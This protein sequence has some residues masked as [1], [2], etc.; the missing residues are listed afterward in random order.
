MSGDLDPDEV[1]A[2]IDKYFGQWQPG[3]DVTQPQFPEQPVLTEP[4]DT[5]V[6]GLEAEQLWLGWR[7]DKA[8]SLQ[9]DTLEIVENMLSNGTAG[10]LDLDIN[11][12]MKMLEAWGG[13][14]TMMDYSLFILSGTPKDGQSLDEVRQLLLDEIAKLKKGEFSEDLLPSV[15]NNLRLRYYNA[16][17]VNRSRADMFV[18][19][20]IN[21]TPWDQQTQRI[22]RMAGMTKQQIV[23]F[24][25]RHFTDGYAAVYKRQGVD[26]NQKKI[27]K[28]AIT[29]ISANRNN[30][31]QFV[32]DIQAVEVK[33]IEP[34]FVDFDRDLTQGRIRD[35]AIPYAYVKNSENGRFQLSFRYTF[36]M[37]ADARYENAAEYLDYLGTDSLTATQLKQQFYKLACNYSIN[38]GDRVITVSLNGLSENMAE[39]VRLLEN[40]MANAK[41]D[42]AAYSQYVAITEKART[43]AK[44]DQRTCFDRLFSYGV[45]GPYNSNRNIVA[46]EELR[47]TDP[48][49]LLDLLKNLRQYEH[50]VLYYGPMSEAELS[51][52]LKSHVEGM[53]GELK[54]VPENKPYM[55]IQTPENEILIAPYDAKN[56]YM[57]MYHNELRQW[58]ADEAPVQMLF[59]EYFGGGMNTIVFQ[60][61]R[62]TR[63]L[64][65]NAWA[66]YRQPQY[67]N[68]VEDFFTHIITQNDKMMDCVNQFHAI[69]DTLPKSETSFQ[70]AKEGLIKQLASQRTTKFGIISAWIAAKNLG[71]DYDLNR[72]VYEALPALTFDDIVSFANAQVAHKPY[73]YII[74]GDEKELDLHALQQYGP[75]RRVS[76]SEI[77]GY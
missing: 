51:D 2:T 29:P 76:I 24:A 26:K 68:E 40:L 31:S 72:K 63:G 25:N 12:Q 55:S 64:A 17:E 18:D 16:I 19:A 15:V 10:L 6:V 32:K 23:D 22:D 7:F 59:N 33:P 44:L 58:N 3:D 13:A 36:G 53:T 47:K 4:Q 62:E 39:A 49:Q 74:L 70:I 21:G 66:I 28:P 35:T 65:Y 45:Y 73:R 41:V 56:I 20:F 60:E 1:I 42:S 75:V 50:T 5:T 57:R 54:P 11:Q 46:V 43:D 48:Q 71:I 30:V 67:K 8:A 77:F 27:D 9:A 69:L 52:A 61:L 38:V 34:K 14:E 37:Q